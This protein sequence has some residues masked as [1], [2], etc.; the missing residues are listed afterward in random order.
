MNQNRREEVLARTVR[1]EAFLDSAVSEAQRIVLLLEN[2]Q[3]KSTTVDLRGR[4][5]QLV[6]VLHR[7]QWEPAELRELIEDVS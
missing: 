6:V 5:A 7:I 3:G 4:A 1:L 2:D